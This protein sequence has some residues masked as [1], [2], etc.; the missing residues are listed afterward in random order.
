MPRQR[1]LE[2]GHREEND[3]EHDDIRPEYIDQI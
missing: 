1:K 2:I 3:L